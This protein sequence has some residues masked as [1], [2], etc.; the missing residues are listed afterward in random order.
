ME[1]PRT[2]EFGIAYSLSSHISYYDRYVTAERRAGDWTGH[3][4]YNSHGPQPTAI[5][6]RPQ[7]SFCFEAVT[8]VPYLEAVAELR[9]AVVRNE[10]VAVGIVYKEPNAHLQC[11]ARAL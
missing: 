6:D 8:M 3:G 9:I 1:Q 10:V 11:T 7:H 5:Y 2:V 4:R